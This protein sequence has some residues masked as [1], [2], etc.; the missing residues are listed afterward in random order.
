MKI[1][2][3]YLI[4]ELFP[5][6]LAGLSFI[7]FII[8]INNIVQL[9]GF[10]IRNSVSFMVFLKVVVNLL[11]AAAIFGVP[12]AILFG[13][14]IGIGRLS[15][16]SEI[17]A[18]RACGFSL[19]RFI[20]PT[21]IFALLAMFADL[22]ISLYWLPHS[23]QQL[24][25]LYRQ[26]LTSRT[27]TSQIKPRVF[28]EDIP[29][30]VLY[31]SRLTNRDRVWRDVILFDTTRAYE[32]SIIFAKQAIPY[33]EDFGKGINLKLGDVYIY[34]VDLKDPVHRSRVTFSKEMVLRLL[35]KRQF[36]D[37]E[38]IFEKSDRAQTV[39]ELRESV[40]KTFVDNYAELEFTN[41]T[42]NLKKILVVLT[43]NAREKGDSVKKEYPFNFAVQP[44]ASQAFTLTFTLPRFKEFLGMGLKISSA[45]GG[46]QRIIYN[47]Y[48]NAD[49]INQKYFGN[50]LEIS[51]EDAMNQ[52][53][54]FKDAAGNDE[55][56]INRIKIDS[57]RF[58]RDYE[59]F[60][61]EIHKKYAIP[62]SCII[63]GLLGLPLGISAR[64]AG[65]SFGYLVSIII[66]MSYWYM[67]LNGEML[68]DTGK[69]SPFI[70]AWG[71]DI[72]F[73]FI[74]GW[75]L[76]QMRKE[77]DFQL[78]ERSAALF[79]SVR[80]AVLRTARNI[81]WAVGSVF[82][83]IFGKTA[84]KDRRSISSAKRPGAERASRPRDGLKQ[85]TNPKLVIQVK[86]MYM[87]FPNL[88]DRY[89]LLSFIRLFLLIL[90]VLYAISVIVQF[91]EINDDINKN[92]I[93]YSILWNYYRYRLPDTLL[94]LIPISAL[95]ATLA[96]FGIMTRNNE[97]VAVK[98]A[99]ISQ[100]RMA[101]PVLVMALLLSVVTFNISEKV[102][103]Q[104]KVKYDEV[105]R[106]IRNLKPQTLEQVGRQ[107]LFGKA[108][109]N[110]LNRIYY[111][112]QYDESNYRFSKISFYDYD[113]V[114]MK[115]AQRLSADSAYW[116]EEFQGW[117]FQNGWV[118]KFMYPG[119]MTE[120]FENRIYQLDENPEYFKRT[121]QTPDQ[122]NYEELRKLIG[123][124]KMK[125]F[126]PVYEQVRLFWKL[127]YAIVTFVVVI[128]GIPFS[129]R[130]DNKG[131]L[132]GIFISLVIVLIYYPMTNVLKHLGYS[133]VLPPLLAAWGG[134]LLFI[135]LSLFLMFK[136]RT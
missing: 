21:L 51:F 134:N 6:T 116:D 115:L 82:L 54:L 101:V 113:P 12:M 131:S 8:L 133:G 129:F 29:D 33:D 55:I 93:P 71:A 136:M 17:T 83:R 59:H 42:S 19:S 39:K 43:V 68:A 86:R 95:V 78:I 79:Y 14:I 125:G 132:S 122:M 77:K 62:F 80:G 97:T 22:M 25:I 24:S 81:S 73:L 1:F 9:A 123:E 40:K 18:F 47:G 89:I 52:R 31:V 102:L 74:A 46:G 36:E 99:G 58:R 45:D 72:F 117:T 28:I 56:T 50:K 120:V 65:R 64:K 11:P 111:F 126:D 127:A 13:T 53:L 5:F 88:I 2:D 103:P 3:K 34:N 105:K 30:K 85:Q 87:R 69:I 63:F 110:N 91:T 98:A 90:L 76:I 108:Q 118:Q 107:F 130:M 124:L 35:E 16:D 57:F 70:G 75:L 4:K 128:V 49:S 26:I 23:N 27:L 94:L 84:S 67:L 7:T 60:F 37:A 32:P 44:L 66:F 109:I 114:T 119:I 61:V 10:L 20:K 48:E 92:N 38:L 15:A 121:W 96:T 100:Y 104:S 106:K 41:K 112:Y 135:F